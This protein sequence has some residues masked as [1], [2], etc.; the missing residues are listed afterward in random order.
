M[1][2]VV[3]QKN[4]RKSLAIFALFLLILLTHDRLQKNNVQTN[5]RF[6][7]VHEKILYSIRLSFTLFFLNVAEKFHIIKR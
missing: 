5:C 1:G 7:V 2:Q 6:C 4:F 3:L